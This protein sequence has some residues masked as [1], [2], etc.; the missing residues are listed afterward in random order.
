VTVAQAI[1]ESATPPQPN[2]SGGWGTSSLYVQANNPF[3][4]KF[5]QADAEYGSFDAPT[6]EIILGQ[7]QNVMAEFQKYPDLATAFKEHARLLLSK[8]QIVAAIPQGWVAVC[9]ALGPPPG[10]K[11]GFYQDATHCGYSTSPA[12]SLTLQELVSEC[13][14]TDPRALGWYATGADPAQKPF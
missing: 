13:R 11:P 2:G 4:I 6:F 1:L 12:Y 9:D 14:L 10:A 3:G 5:S 7:R 8:P